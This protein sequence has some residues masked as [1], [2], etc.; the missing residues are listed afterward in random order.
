[1]KHAHIGQKREGG[2]K[3]E[4]LPIYVCGGSCIEVVTK[5]QKLLR[6]TTYFLWCHCVVIYL[7]VGH[8]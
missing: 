6:H 7:Q 8:S 2:E 5:V 4:S 3:K 1:M